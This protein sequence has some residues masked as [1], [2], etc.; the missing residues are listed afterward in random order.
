MDL[1]RLVDIAAGRIPADLVL[2]GGRIVNVLSCEIHDGDV[3]I[4]GSSP[5]VRW[6]Q[7]CEKATGLVWPVAWSA[8]LCAIYTGGPTGQAR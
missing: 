8:R 4:A 7:K 2:R 1:K 5:I 6:T 3:A